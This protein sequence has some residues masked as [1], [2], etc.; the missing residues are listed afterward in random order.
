MEEKTIRT[1]LT[2][3][4]AEEKDLPEIVRIYNSTIA[5]GRVTADTECVSVEEKKAWF[6]A[7]NPDKRPLWIAEK[8]G[9]IIGWA[10][11]QSFYGRPAYN[12]TVEISIYIDETY[13][14]Q[15]YGREILNY[16]IT[17]APL[18]GIQTLLGF[19]FAHNVESI[20]LFEHAGF[21]EWGNLPNIA[22]LFGQE[23]SLKIYGKRLF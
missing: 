15:G 13:R 19:I 8:K 3:R 22:R 23:E 9:K 7:H 18:F 1:S 10:G 6:L 12:A 20:R 4:I 21:N 2:F 14:G 17:Q 11:F 5:S 16:C